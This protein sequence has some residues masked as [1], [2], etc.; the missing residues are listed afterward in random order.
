MCRVAA[1]QAGGRGAAWVSCSMRIWGIRGALI[2]RRGHSHPGA[3]LV[4][5]DRMEKWLRNP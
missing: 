5:E 3:W 4:L 1:Y 2:R